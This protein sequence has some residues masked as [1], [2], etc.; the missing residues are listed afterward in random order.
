MRGYGSP[1]ILVDGRDIEGVGPADDICCCRLYADA[2]SGFQGAPSVQSIASALQISSG[3]PVSGR[4]SERIVGWRS[5]LATLPGI[6]LA[7]LPKLV[8]PACWPAYAGL[9]SSLGLGLLLNTAYLLPLTLL[10]LMIALGALGLR[11]KTRR[12][13]GP[14]GIGLLASGIVLGGKF[15]LNSNVAIYGGLAMLVAASLW[16]GWPRRRSREGGYPACV[17]QGFTPRHTGDTQNTAKEVIT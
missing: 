1:T 8:C 5:S 3:R 10:F 17:P 14:L 6:A 16:N 9:L 4:S 2:A 7:G 11:A 12:G 13:Y 15:I